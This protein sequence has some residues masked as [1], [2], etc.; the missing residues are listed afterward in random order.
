MKALVV[1]DR[2]VRASLFAASLRQAAAEHGLDFDIAEF[3]LEY[4]SADRLPLPA[5]AEGAEFR[6]MWEVPSEVIRRAEADLA[7][8]PTLREYSGPVDL[9]V[10]HLADCDV[11]LVHLAPVSRAA[12]AVAARLR[13]V[14]CARGGPININL[15][16]LSQRGIALFN[17]P[18]R[19]SR[20]VAEFLAGAILSLTRNIARGSQELSAG[21]WRLD[22]YAQEHTGHEL[23]GRTCG[24]IGFGAVGRA[25]AP[26]AR[27][28]GLKLQ[29][30]DPY[31]DDAEL[32]AE[33]AAR[34]TLDQVLSTSDVV[35]V[36]ARLT[37]E[38]RGMLGRRE[39]DLLQPS[40]VFVNTARSEIVDP[41]ALRAAVARGQRVIVDVFSPEPPLRDDPLLA[42]EM[43]LLT[44]HIAGASREAAQRGADVAA[45]SVVAYLADGSLDNCVN[46]AALRPEASG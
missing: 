1:G 24:L 39:L 31:I 42:S 37:A 15:E 7:A 40:A 30:H 17:C 41:T 13:A 35:I 38:T 36:A 43:A 26:I 33:G 22:L 27:G 2:F 3:Q 8:D 29:V 19:N 18:G 20:A 23:Y 21:Y 34:A 9:L 14:G 16:A 11:L 6:P 10:P 28:F 5:S 44:P 12:I 45:R 46:A 4:P 32:A 25:F